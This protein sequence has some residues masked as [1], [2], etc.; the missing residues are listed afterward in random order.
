MLAQYIIDN[1]LAPVLTESFGDCEL[2]LGTLV[3]GMDQYPLDAGRNRR[4]HH[5]CFHGRQRLSRMR[6]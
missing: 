1:K 6:F 2:D 5:R 3:N 4:H